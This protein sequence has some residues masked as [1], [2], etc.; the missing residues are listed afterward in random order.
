AGDSA[1]E[2]DLAV[3]AGDLEDYRD[4]HPAPED[5][6]L[7]IEVAD[8]SP[9]EDRQ[10][11]RRYAWAGIPVVW[12]IN[13][14]NETVEVYTEPTGMRLDASYA[15]CEIQGLDAVLSFPLSDLGPVG[16]IAVASLLA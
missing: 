6:A 11:L 1:P 5:I 16:P 13:L 15:R 10:G 2:P 8:S 3:I 7:I 12:V 14:T 4:A 9:P